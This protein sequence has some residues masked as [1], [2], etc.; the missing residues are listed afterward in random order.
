M[1]EWIARAPRVV[2]LPAGAKRVE[3]VMDEAGRVRG[4]RRVDGFKNLRGHK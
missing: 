1:P 3:G 2:E 4:W